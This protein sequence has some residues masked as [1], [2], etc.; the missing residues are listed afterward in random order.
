MPSGPSDPRAYVRI[1]VELPSHPKIAALDDPVASWAH[2]VAICYSGEH[3]TNGVFP[4]AAIL[5]TAGAPRTKGEKLIRAGLWHKPG[6]DC[7]DCAQPPAAHAVVHDYLK[8]QNSDTH[9]RTVSETRSA[10]GR[11]G[12][13]ARWQT[14]GKPHG[15]PHSKPVAN[16][17]ANGWQPDGN[18]HGK[19]IAEV[20]SK[21]LGGDLGGNRYVSNAPARVTEP[22][23][24]TP[25]SANR[26]LERCSEHRD[27]N[28]DPGPCRGCMKAREHAQQWD[29]DTLRQR[30]IDV[31][32]CTWCDPDGWRIDP[33]HKHRGPISPAVRCDH[34]PLPA[35]QLQES[36]S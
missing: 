23:H 31:R 7:P 32:A 24:E 4:L 6:H 3:L 1:A 21:N 17:I 10:A 26:P 28:T 5:R 19:P 16:A 30:V 34:T 9:V 14:D 27:L 18:L 8:H 29:K 22:P 2:V 36:A 11:R 12:A 35:E 15:K 33:R 13:A 25:S 20:R